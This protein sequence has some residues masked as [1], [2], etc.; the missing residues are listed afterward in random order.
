MTAYYQLKIVYAT[1]IRNIFKTCTFHLVHSIVHV[2]KGI[3]SNNDRLFYALKS[4]AD[5]IFS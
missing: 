2:D 5:K 3:S 1:R 4:P